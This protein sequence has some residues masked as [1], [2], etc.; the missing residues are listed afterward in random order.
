VRRVLALCD[1]LHRI[2]G[3]YVDACGHREDGRPD[4]TAVV[5][6]WAVEEAAWLLAEAGARRFAINAGGDIAV[7]GGIAAGQPWR[8]GIRHPGRA[9]RLA[10][11]LELRDGAVAT[12]GAYERGPHIVDAHT[13]SAPKGLVSLT[14]ADAYATAAYAMGLDGL[15][16]VEAHQGFAA[17]VIAPDDRVLWT[18]GLDAYL[19]G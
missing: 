3:G 1:D 6:G 13:G 8:V 5:K 11:A 2:G 19:A 16:W 12:S 7:R 9:D 15:A 10:T 4:P 17:H 14:S 18:A